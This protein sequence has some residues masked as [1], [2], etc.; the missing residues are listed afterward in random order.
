[1]KIL[2]FYLIKYNKIKMIKVKKMTIELKVDA[3]IKYKTKFKILKNTTILYK[4]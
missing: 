2:K 3:M 4:I 1:M